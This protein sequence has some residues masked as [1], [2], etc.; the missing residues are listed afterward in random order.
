MKQSRFMSALET[1]LSTAAGFGLSLLIQWLV[2]GW[3]LGIEIPLRTNIVFAV[4]MTVVSLLRGFVM[5]RIFE[6]LN[7]RRP[8]SPAMQAVIAERFRQIEVEGFDLTHDDAH[9]LGE[10]ALAGAA[11]A[12]SSKPVAPAIFPWPD[13][14]WKPGGGMR[15]N[16]IKAAALILA[17]IEKFDRNRKRLRRE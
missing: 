6:A 5:R 10:L 11:Y 2:L 15:R 14:W 4:I 13:E 17:E 1:T 3:L 12:S 8:L 16:W 7:I 9:Y